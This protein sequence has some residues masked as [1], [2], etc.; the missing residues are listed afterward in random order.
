LTQ[1]NDEV[2]VMIGSSRFAKRENAAQKPR[3]DERGFAHSSVLLVLVHLLTLAG[4]STINTTLDLKSTSHFDTGNSAFYS[5]EAGV[6]HALSSMNT[7]GVVRFKQD[8]AD[9][10]SL[11]YGTTTKSMP[12]FQ[13]ISYTATVTADATNPNNRGTLS[14]TG[15]APLQAQRSIN[16][17]LARGGFSGAP[18]AIYL[19]ANAINAQFTGN[20]F[21]VDG[22]DH[23]TL[24][25]LVPGGVVKPGI[26]ARTDTVR[27]EVVNSLNTAQ[28]DNVRGLGFSLSPLAPSVLNTGGPDIDDLD[29]IVANLLTS[30][31]VVTNSTAIINGNQTFGSLASPAI[32]RLTNSDVTLNGNATGA[33]ILV[34]DGSITISGTL[35][36]VGWIIVRGATIINSTGSTDDQTFVLGD[37]TIMGSLW[38]GHLD[39]RVGGHALVNYCSACLSLVDNIGG[40]SG[41]LPRPMRIVYWEEVL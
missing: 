38:T 29:R 39:I 6:M 2:L 35:D 11:L 28:M 13:K 30:P 15:S 5:A 26:S 41:T 7:V 23:T 27:D 20:T 21:E 25:A 34:V 33:G 40:I 37:A 22:N 10:W 36:F 9:R 12:G 17:G 31:G 4:A 1:L 16:V 18:G 3:L 19:A 14:V 8:V 32:T 24:G